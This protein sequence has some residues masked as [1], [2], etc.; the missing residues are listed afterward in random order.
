MSKILKASVNKESL[1]LY[2]EILRMT[3]DFDNVLDKKG[4]AM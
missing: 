4:R 2:R 3:Y 1:K